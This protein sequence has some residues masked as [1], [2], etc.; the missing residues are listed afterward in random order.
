[1]AVSYFPDCSRSRHHTHAHT[2]E[3]LIESGE[4]EEK[5]ERGRLGSVEQ[6][7]KKRRERELLNFDTW[8]LSTSMSSPR[9]KCLCS[10]RMSGMFWTFISMPLNSW[11]NSA[12]AVSDGGGAEEPIMTSPR[13]SHRWISARVSTMLGILC[14]VDCCCCWTGLGVGGG[15]KT[16]PLPPPAPDDSADRPECGGEAEVLPLPPSSLL[17]VL[18]PPPLR[19]MPADEMPE[20]VD[21][22]CG[23]LRN[24]AGWWWWWC[25]WW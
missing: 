9:W 10:G 14:R 1:M 7:G 23:L 4:C 12:V 13:P 24:W 5:G 18:L 25:R 22:T 8:M 16:P 11:S 20:S 21:A 2:S 3:D 6:K 17:C 19:T 15:S